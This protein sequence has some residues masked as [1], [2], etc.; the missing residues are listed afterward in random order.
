MLDEVSR[1]TAPG[2]RW[3]L[4][5]LGVA[6]LLLFG[7][8]GTH[9]QPV[10]GRPRTV[11][12]TPEEPIGDGLPRVTGP[13]GIGPA[14]LRLLVSGPNPQVVDAHSGRS[15]PV[16][17]LRLGRDE[18]AL[19][20]VVPGALVVSVGS[21]SSVRPKSSLLVPG[22]RPVPL[23][24]DVRVV[25]AR[26][27]G[28]LIVS[29]YGPGGTSVVVTGRTGRIRA[30]WVQP[31]LVT[32]LV[33]TAAGLLVARSAVAGSAAV[34]L[35]LV[36]P[37]TGVRRRALAT[38]RTV[39]AVGPTAVAH[40]PAA[41]ARACRLTVTRLAGGRSR[42]YPTP[43]AGLPSRGAFSPDGRWLALGVPGQYLNGRL[44]VRPGFTAVLDLA[45]GTVQQV[46]GVETSAERTADLSWWGRDHLVLGVWR[47]D[48]ASVALWSVRRP[49]EPARVLEVEPPGNYQHSSVTV[50][51]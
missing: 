28:D 21:A 17:G 40:V 23:G 12:P 29:S 31:G 3:G 26:R 20:Q 36:D 14:G 19:V 13:R 11:A 30:D 50:L 37:A 44:A 45:T 38:K 46:G 41:C 15:S 2:R 48:R 34:D 5:V 22:G 8:V 18:G 39:V 7:Y 16:P 49:D 4:P 47:D 6:V 42:D 10:E 32:P 9:R 43:D 1:G 33:D 25:P 27:G 24:D 51:P 35:L